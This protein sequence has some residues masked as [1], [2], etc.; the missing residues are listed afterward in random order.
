M[1]ETT[2]DLELGQPK[3]LLSHLRFV[4]VQK[5]GN[6]LLVL[7]LDFAHLAGDRPIA[8]EVRGQEGCIRAQTFGPNSGHGGTHAELSRFIRSSAHHGAIPTPR[9]NDGFA[10]QLRIVALLH[11]RIKCVH[12]DMNDLASGHLAPSYSGVEASASVCL[13]DGRLVS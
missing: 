13:F 4:V 8:W 11:G 7:S 6:P 3:R 5:T 2:L 10:A 12:V 1:A 9:H